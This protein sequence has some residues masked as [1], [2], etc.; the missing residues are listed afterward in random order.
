MLNCQQASQM[1][2]QSLD[3]RLTWRERFNLRLHLLICTYCSRFSQQLITL[4][5]AFKRIGEQIEQDENILLPIETKTR[6][7][8][9]LDSV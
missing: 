5:S 7:A 8:K 3:R 1:I 9:E 6:I 4:R 2:S